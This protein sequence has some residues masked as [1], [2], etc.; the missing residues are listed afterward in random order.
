MKIE[1]LKIDDL[2]LA[3]E[4][5]RLSR[6][7]SA[8]VDVADVLDIDSPHNEMPSAFCH[9]REFTI[10]ERE[11]LASSRTHV[12]W[13]RTS[14]VDDPSEYRVPKDLAGFLDRGV[15]VATRRKMLEAK[16]RGDSQDEW[17]RLLPVSSET[18]FVMRLS[19]RD[20]IKYAK[21]F[22]YLSARC[23]AVLSARFL[24]VAIAL[25]R[26][27]DRFTGSSKI[28]LDAA[29]SMS[30]PLLLSEEAMIKG[31]GEIEDVGAI[32]V[33]STRVP[34]WLR[35]HFARHRPI[36][37]VDDLFFVLQRDDVLDL[38]IS[39]PL[40]IQVAASADLWAAI[41]GKRSCWLAQSSLSRERDPWQEIID[42]FGSSTLPCHDGICKYRG[43]AQNRVDGSD[44]GVPCPRYLRLSGIDAAPHLARIH[45]ALRSRADHW[46]GEVTS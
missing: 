43:D 12:M 42:S 36:T 19:Y 41:L 4:A 33:L 23:S 46:L 16:G 10:L 3:A 39:H 1:V 20:A 44:P 32:R 8:E 15:H 31:T 40:R 21:Y 45:E 35:A 17:R 6:D 9:F 27:V 11:I 7:V 38:P 26:V 30:L 24:K 29:E 34:L 25:M 18:A 5:W 13:A 37:I 28:S 2:T 14:F 22:T